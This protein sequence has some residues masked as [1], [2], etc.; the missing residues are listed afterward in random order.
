MKGSLMLRLCKSLGENSQR[1]YNYV[2]YFVRR[3][4]YT[5]VLSHDAVNWTVTFRT[6]LAFRTD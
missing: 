4:R 3:S 1:R 5:Q 2:P 6:G